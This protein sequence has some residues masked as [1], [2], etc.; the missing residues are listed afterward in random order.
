VHA[1]YAE[2]EVPFSRRRPYMGDWSKTTSSSKAKSDNW[3]NAPRRNAKNR[4]V[5]DIKTRL[6]PPPGLSSG[7]LLRTCQSSLKKSSG[8]ELLENRVI[9]RVR[10]DKLLSSTTAVRRAA[11]SSIRGRRVCSVSRRPKQPREVINALPPSLPSPPK[12]HQQVLLPPQDN[13]VPL[14]PGSSPGPPGANQY[15]C[16]G[17]SSPSR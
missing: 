10:R 1:Q 17:K 4:D 3:G 11:R 2:P 6:R 12:F 8:I 13:A 15:P 9:Y 16:K 5:D 14:A 7:V